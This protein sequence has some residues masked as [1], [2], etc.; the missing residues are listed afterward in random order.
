MAA[1]YW[2]GGSA[3][4]DTTAGTKWALTSGGAGGQAVPTSADDV[5]FDAASG[6]VTCTLSGNLN[7]KSITCTGF[8]GTLTGGP[9]LSIYGNITLVS[10]M[11]YSVNGN[12]SLL[13]PATITCA[14]KSISFNFDIDPSTGTVTLA[15]AFTA[16]N[17]VR[18][19]SGTLQTNNFNITCNSISLGGGTSVLFGSST[20]TANSFSDNGATVTAGTST[21]NIGSS[22]SSTSKTWPTVT[23]TSPGGTLTGSGTVT[24]TSLTFPTI[25]TNGVFEIAFGT[26]YT[27]GTLVC[28]GASAVRRYFMRSATLGTS[29]SLSVTTWSTISDIDF[30]DISLNSTRSGTRLGNCGGNTNITFPAAKTVYWNLTGVQD[31]A[32]TGWATTAGGA[33]AVANFPLAQDTA[34]F[35]NTGALTTVTSGSNAWNVGTIDMS[36][37]TSAGTVGIGSLIIYGNLT[38]GSGITVDGNIFSVEFRGR[39]TTQTITSAGKTLSNRFS[40]YAIGGTVRLGDALTLSNSNT[41]MTLFNGTFNT[42]N[43]NLTL[44][45]AGSRFL[46]SGTATKTLTLGSSL[47]TI[48]GQSGFIASSPS[49]GTTI[50]ANTATISLTSSGPKSFDG[51][52]LNYNGLTVNQGGAGALTISGANTFG[53]ITNTYSATGATTITFTAATTNTFS[54]WNASG[55]AAKLLTINSTGA[56]ATVSK[57]SGVVSAD[58]LSISNSTATG[59]A[60]WYA[61]ANSTNG[62]GNTGWIFS[63]APGA[64]SSNFLMLF[65]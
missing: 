37:R 25:T 61:G 9:N 10:G 21:L 36:G 14:G 5:F 64:S 28:S 15:D 39:N 65:M 23:F 16:T 47:V 2:V 51:A 29:R 58:Y 22:F 60:T 12:L 33:P 62:G 30:Q 20:V 19:L 55:A 4:W 31:W 63:A 45:D 53:N 54:N 7:A 43:F 41:P 42:Q 49:T 56:A 57:S 35:T 48:A 11:T 34:T 6:A 8:T 27:V 52:G 26:N 24:I 1:R 13:A 32:A 40:I 17:G 44:T 18:V 38:Y 46:I 50:T 59:G 3:T